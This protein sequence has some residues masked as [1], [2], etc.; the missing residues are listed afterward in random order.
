MTVVR[1]SS[2][3]GSL[4]DNDDEGC[5]NYMGWLL[6]GSVLEKNIA[7]TQVLHAGANESSNLHSVPQ[8]WYQSGEL[9]VFLEAN[10]FRETT[11]PSS[12][13]VM[14]GRVH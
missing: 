8:I 14:N 2:L 5:L 9:F 10:S 3:E 4:E 12:C 11:A 1:G 13:K 6:L 7:S